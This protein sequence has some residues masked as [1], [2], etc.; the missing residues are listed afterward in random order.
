[1][2]IK[3]RKKSSRHRGSK[4]HS[5]GA[6]KKARGKGHKGGKGMAGTGKRA[7]QKKTLVLKKYGSQYF[8]KDK[9]LR[10]KPQ[11]KP[12]VINLQY[13]SDNLESLKNKG[14]A[15]ET[16]S[17]FEINLA[18]YKLLAQG[19]LPPNKII[20]IKAHSASKSAIEKLK[21]LGIKLELKSVT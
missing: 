7:D 4:T 14:I 16:K 11:K 6:M 2:K 18:K 13:I 3:K 12:D 15:K 21:T 5:R 20:K 1:M 10:R 9:T 17:G 8:G 19:E